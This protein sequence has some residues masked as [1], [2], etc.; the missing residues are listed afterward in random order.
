MSE[1]QLLNRVRSYTSGTPGRSLNNVRS[2][3]FVIDEPP[4]AGG[5]GEEIT[6]AEAF[7]AGVS[8]CGVLLVESFARRSGVPLERAEVIIEGV[9]ARANPVDFESISMRFDL[10]GPSREQAEELVAYYQKH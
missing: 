2:H 9:R 4:Y 1:H 8:S 5:P 10:V 3:H 6:P 7:L